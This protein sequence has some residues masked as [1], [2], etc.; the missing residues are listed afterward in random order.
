MVGGQIGISAI[1][2]SIGETA[3]ARRIPIF[4]PTGREMADTRTTSQALESELP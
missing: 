3:F 4:T 1:V 2:A